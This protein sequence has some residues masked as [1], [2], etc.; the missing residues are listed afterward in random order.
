[1]QDAQS[2]SSQAKTKQ[3]KSKEE[4][5]Q[6]VQTETPVHHSNVQAYSTKEKV[7]SRVGHKYAPFAC[8]LYTM[9]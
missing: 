9:P 6:I 7:R 1:M 5:G 4:Q 3:P 2:A 8:L